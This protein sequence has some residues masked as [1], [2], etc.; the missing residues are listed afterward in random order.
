MKWTEISV[1]TTNE[2]VEAVSN[3]FHE[4]GASGVVI[5]DSTEIEKVRESIWRNLCIKSR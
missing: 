2:A 5:E 4:A 1:L 3:I